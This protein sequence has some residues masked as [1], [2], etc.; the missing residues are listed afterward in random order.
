MSAL[1]KDRRAL[2]TAGASGIGRVIA[3][4]LIEAGARCMVCDVDTAALDAFRSTFGKGLAVRADVSDEAQVDVMFDQVEQQ[5]GGLDILVNNAGI[6]GPTLPAEELS[7][8]DWQRTIAVNLDGHFLCARRAI[9]LLRDAG[10]GSIVNMSSIGGRLGY[11]KRAAYAAA[12]WG[13]I[14]FTKTLSI[15]LGPLGIRVNAIQPGMVEGPRVE[16]VMREKAASAGISYETLQERAFQR[17]SLRR[18]VTAEDVAAL[19]VF[20]VSDAGRNISGQAIPVDGD[21]TSLG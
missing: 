12:K 9:P 19:V 20:L 16:R 21:Q 13:I 8:E 7:L 1:L 5:L 11:P 3:E 10:G 4:R 2:V 17:I 14:G 18:G 15:E 6:S